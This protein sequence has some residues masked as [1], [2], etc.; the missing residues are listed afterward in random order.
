MAGEPAAVPRTS[1]W[2]PRGGRQVRLL[3]A[4]N[5]ERRGGVAAAGVRA[6]LGAPA[7]PSL[8]SPTSKTVAGRDQEVEEQAAA[9]PEDSPMYPEDEMKGRQVKRQKGCPAGSNR[10]RTASCGWKSA[11]VAPA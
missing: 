5:R 10:T 9:V 11:R 6:Q 4:T 1:A 8:S 2:L 7:S 3:V